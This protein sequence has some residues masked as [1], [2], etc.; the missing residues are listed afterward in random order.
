MIETQELTKSFVG[1]TAVNKLNLKVN[2]GEILGLIGPNGSGKTTVFNLLTGFLKPTSGKIFFEGEEISRK[3]PHAR[4]KLGMARTFQLI[5]VF[6]DFTISRNM[7][8][9]A[10]LHPKIGW[11]EAVFDIPQY[12]RK[13]KQV[14]E[15]TLKI[16]KF[17]GLE[18]QKDE[19]AK[20]LPHGHQKL[21][22]I[23]LALATNPKLLL[24]DEPLAGMSP[25]EVDAAL[26]IIAEIRRQGKTI[27][28]IEH[29]MAAV[30]N[31]CDRIVALNFGTEIANGL[32]EEVSKN[33]DVIQAYLG[34]G[35]NAT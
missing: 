15:E 4:A 5:R 29:N 20:N 2:K 13:D 32:P 14:S 34:V 31:I 10:H 1:L 30:M 21:L 35:E 26:E 11:W 6:R 16:L 27:L 18:G 24:L 3:P 28:L 9:A 7:V 19:I 17:L 22:S 8:A 25:K 23:A 12:R 33:Q